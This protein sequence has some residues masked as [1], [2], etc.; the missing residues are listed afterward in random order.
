MCLLG[1]FY[2]VLDRT[3]ITHLMP[4]NTRRCPNIVFSLAQRRRRR[5]NIKPKLGLYRVIGILGGALW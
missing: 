2:T 5:A 3:S 4:A 1:I